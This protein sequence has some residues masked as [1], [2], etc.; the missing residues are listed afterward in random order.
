LTSPATLPARSSVL[1]D[2][3]LR[4]WVEQTFELPP[5]S[6][7]RLISLSLNDV[8]RITAGTRRIY[9]RIYRFGVRSEA[10][11]AAELHLCESL[12]GSGLS[13][14]A[15]IRGR[16]GAAFYPIAAV[17]GIRHAA[18][19]EEAPGDD[20]REITIRQAHAYGRLAAQ[21]HAATDALGT[22]FERPRL[23]AATLIDEPLAAIRC[24]LAGE[25]EL[26]KLELVASEVKRR[27]E[28][29]LQQSSDV[30]LC[31][32]DL[33]PGNVRFADGARPTLFDFDC[34]G[35][36]WR[37]YDLAV[38][39]W[40]SYGERRPRRWR[41]SRWKAFLKAYSAIRPIPAGLDAH[42]ADFLAARQIWLTGL[43][44]AGQSGYP[45]QWV[46]PQ[47]LRSTLTAIDGWFD[48]FSTPTAAR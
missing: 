48:E 4:E 21:I 37:G 39:L 2:Q 35:Y 19:L 31:H 17:E 30:G 28:S 5:I 20:A 16:D 8:Y 7:C 25:A 13:I 6:D 40:N 36:G 46:G 15:P 44:F 41:A 42:L 11:V 9:L 38:F 27:L 23:D 43:D 3:G 24:V 18:L 34:C 33:H 26:A 45:P 32:G 47:L 10:E 29:L 22:T 14:A 1:D 12:V